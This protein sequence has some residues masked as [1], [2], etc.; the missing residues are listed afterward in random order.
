[1][2]RRRPSTSRR[3]SGDGSRRTLNSWTGRSPTGVAM[4]F[5]GSMLQ[6]GMP[7]ID[8]SL[9]VGRGRGFRPVQPLVAIRND[10]T[11]EQC[12]RALT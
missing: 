11:Y 9:I 2:P 6:K 5:D 1:M 3:G 10:S 12:A 8:Q 4:L 7:D